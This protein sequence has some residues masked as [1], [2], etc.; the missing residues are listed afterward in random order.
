MLHRQF[1]N[2]LMNSDDVSLSIYENYPR[3]NSIDVDGNLSREKR[4]SNG[5]MEVNLRYLSAF[6]QISRKLEVLQRRYLQ[7]NFKVWFVLV[8]DQFLHYRDLA[9]TKRTYLGV[10]GLAIF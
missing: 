8:F 10:C 4:G 9:K 6:C 7:G 2:K 3:M 5:G 1:E